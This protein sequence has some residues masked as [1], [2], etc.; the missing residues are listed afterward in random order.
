MFFLGLTPTSES[1]ALISA[2]TGAALALG[3]GNVNLAAWGKVLAGLAASL[4]LGYGGAWLLTRTLYRPLA[5]LKAQA[6]ARTQILAAGGMAFMHGAQDG[7]KFVAIFILADLFARGRYPAGPIALSDHLPVV[8]LCGLAMALGT[9]VGGG[10]IVNLVGYKMVR[11][12][13][14]E[15]VCADLGG[16]LCLLL[17][18]AFGVPVSTTHTKTTAMMGAGAAAGGQ[19]SSKV[20]RE[21]VFTWVITFPVCGLLGWAL[22]RLLL[23]I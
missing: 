8:F 22:T 5:A 14:T 17:A 1:H 15:G 13:K 21:I 7:Q 12:Q 6:L 19:V 9:S 20:V 2:I 11:L 3:T 18:S 23:S 4:A 10:R 16:V